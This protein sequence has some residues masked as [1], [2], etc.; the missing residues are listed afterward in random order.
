MSTEQ[1]SYRAALRERHVARSFLPN[2]LGRFSL[3]MSGLALVLLL[4][5]GGGSFAVS[6]AVTAVLGI[7]NV[8]ATPWR[9]RAIDRFGQTGTMSILG[10]I[11]TVVVVGFAARPE[12]GLPVLLFLGVVAGASIPPF[13][14]T[15]RVLWSDALASGP[16]RTR[17]LSLD[18]VA[19]EVIFAVGP[20]VSAVLTTLTGPVLALSASAGCVAVGTV[21]FVSSPL[22]RHRN[23]LRTRAPTSAR[24][25]ATPLRT[26]GFPPVVLAIMVPGVI[27][28]AVEIAAPAL[29][30]AEGATVLPGVI[31][32]LFA[33]S[34]ALGGLLYGRVTPRAS[35]ERQLLVLG[36]CLIGTSAA[37]G[38]IGSTAVLVVGIGVMGAFVA[39]LLI[40]GYIAADT[41][42]D[43][44]ARTEA[45]GWITTSVN[46][47][48]AA[49]SGL[50]GALTGTATPG[51]ALALCTAA[52]ATVLVAAA[53][54]LV[55][56]DR[57]SRHDGDTV[58]TSGESA[59]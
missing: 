58:E 5:S 18:T 43:S 37:A 15:M 55:S 30:A 9:A 42:V 57:L 26:P 44:H 32:A 23:G 7:A 49:G 47:G 1:L 28:G 29:G 48:A 45:N 52:A 40:T 20:L 46:L 12:A 56:N 53:P 4:E 34:S 13:G 14:S 31:L 6:G 27:L 17:G 2:I 54:R 11:H 25:A 10:A 21:L 36:A 16:M 59:G 33:G 35:I 38:I 8:V 3:A 51:T 22:S 50:F 39:P 24:T 19:E 41:R